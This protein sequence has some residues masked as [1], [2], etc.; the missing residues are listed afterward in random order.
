MEFFS[1]LKIRRFF[2]IVHDHGVPD[3]NIIV[4]MFDD[5]AHNDQNPRKGVIINR[6]NGP[7]VSLEKENKIGSAKIN[8]A[9][10]C[11]FPRCTR[12]CRKITR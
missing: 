3:E 10:V 1:D 4:M 11:F 7:N 8:I 5:I 6:P 12:A 9:C 2:Q